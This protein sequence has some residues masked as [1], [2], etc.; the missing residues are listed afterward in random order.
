MT[1]LS[2][3]IMAHPKRAEFI[4]ELEA[5]LDR[6]A[7]VIWDEK[8]DRW[9]TGRRAM[10]AYDP[11]ADAHLVVQDDAIVARDL[12]AGLEQALGHVPDRSPLCAYIGTV[13]PWPTA[14]AQLVKATR[15]D[16]SWIV[17]RQLNWGVAVAVPVPLIDE[18]IAWCDR[19]P[20]VANYDKRMSRW[21]EHQR[22]DVWY[23]WPSLV[24]HR[25]SPSLVPG[26]HG[27]R[28]AH[29]FIG[30]DASALEQRWDGDVMR[31]VPLARGGERRERPSAVELVNV[32]T[33]KRR[34]V[35]VGTAE[36][37]T[38]LGCWVPADEAQTCPSCGAISARES[39]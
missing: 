5:A 6:P 24:D 36:R 26:R 16:T 18:M 23:P 19:R 4:P 39:E 35:P 25:D 33:G 13:R 9:D 10:L 32:H 37:L 17:M 11:A 1:T 22:L 30:A 2:V 38:K 29:R 8:N 3:A 20:D 15:E 12:V 21:F 27:G 31:L 28:H 14:V 34:R 7:K